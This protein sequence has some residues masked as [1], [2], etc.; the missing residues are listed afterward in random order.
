MIGKIKT[1]LTVLGKT[2]S[3]L[4]VVSEAGKKVVS[5]YEG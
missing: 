5:L 2:A 1:V 3:I 4:E